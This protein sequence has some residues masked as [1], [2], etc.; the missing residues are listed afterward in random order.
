MRRR[1]F[2]KYSVAALLC[3]QINPSLA[4]GLVSPSDLD[5]Y[6]GW[7]GKKFKATGF[8]R[9]EKDDRWW[10]VT[11]EGNAFLSFGINHFA[12]YL[13]T[14][15]YNKDAWCKKFGVESVNSPAF[16]QSL[17]KW[18][19]KTCGE[20]GFNTVGVHND[21]KLVNKPKPSMA[22][23]QPIKFIDTPHWKNEVPDE[24]F[25]DVFSDEFIVNA[26]KLAQK[27]CLPVKDD[28]YLLGYS[29]TDCT[30][31]THEDCRERTDVI[32]GARREARIGW[33][34][35]LRNFPKNTAGKKAYVQ[36][37]KN[38]YNNEIESFNKIYSTSFLSF[39][40]LEQAQ[41]WR[42]H[43]HLHNGYEVRD[44]I[45]F[46]KMVVDQYYKVAKSSIQ[47]YDGNHMFVGDKLNG[48]TDSLDSVLPI[49]SKYTDVIFYQ[50]YA[51]YEVQKP[52]LDRWTSLV[53][54]PIING[55]SA[56]TMVT[57][58]MPRPY[59]PVADNLAQRA[60][61]TD[62]FFISA[63]SRKNFVGWHYCGLIDATNQ[64]P[65]KQSRQHSGLL[66]SYGNA[67]P[68]LQRVMKSRSKQ[69]YSLA[70]K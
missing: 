70:G 5:K 24:N 6:G 35:R 53:D 37:M 15:D 58:H 40:V 30:L 52:G 26:D 48:N 57:E 28:P 31:F 51:R 33:V 41:N 7:K 64:N 63:F 4:Q 56:Y 12:P 29:M 50:M 23:M 27:V 3:Q 16:K 17:K 44:N 62:E 2:L 10:L 39:D 45:E 65:R 69:L 49:T 22:Y 13:W 14:Q 34:N 68:E 66:D 25:A 18:F 38:L 61:W 11:P 46:L 21:L 20:F 42:E 55:D 67:Y 8:F 1:N 19:H 47:K 9:T 54:K 32:G 36:L 43:T 60:E 59:G